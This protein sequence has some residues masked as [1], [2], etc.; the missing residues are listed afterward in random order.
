MSARNDV[1]PSTLPVELAAE[2]VY[3]EY[4][5][6]RRVFYNGVPEK[7]EGT[8]RCQPGKEVQ[9]LVTD[10][11]ETEGVMLYVN[12]LNTH[13]DILESTGVG[14]IMLDADEEAEPFPGVTV[15]VDGYAV[16]VTAD[17]DRAR[18]R[19]FVFEEDELGERA[20]ELV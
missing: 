16:E 8:V 15:R 5:D 6:G 10:P 19:V 3:V 20:F 14:R 2:G 9:V 18:G 7:R 17:V 13:D 12:D 1:S 4:L 11:T